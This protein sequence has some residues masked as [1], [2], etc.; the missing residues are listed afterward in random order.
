MPNKEKS[1]AVANYWQQQ[2]EAWQ[3]SSQSQSA[4][5]TANDLAYHR[6]GYWRRKLLSQSRVSPNQTTSSF[7]PAMTYPKQT[8]GDDL[9]LVLPSGL[10]LRGV[11]SDNLSVVCQLLNRL[12]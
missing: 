2:I 5:C 3:A 1:Q 4:F 10:M 11:T 12:S 7:V 9:C 8:A 6:F